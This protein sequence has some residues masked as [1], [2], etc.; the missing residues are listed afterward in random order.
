MPLIVTI[1]TSF[2]N[3][4]LGFVVYRK[5]PKSIT[6]I[7][8]AMITVIIACWTIANYFSLNSS[9][10]IQSLFW[11]QLVMFTTAPLGPVIYLF[12]NAYPF[13]EMKISKNK[14]IFITS[15][16][17]ILAVLSISPLT[18][19]RVSFANGVHPV[20]GP[21]VIMWGIVSL[22]FLILGIK[23]ILTKYR[24]SKGLVKLQL[25][26][27]ILGVILSFTLQFITNFLFVVILNYSNFVIFGP[28]FSLIMIGF[29]TY[30]IIRHRFL[31]IRLLVARTV[32]YTLL[33]AI[34]SIFYTAGFFIIISF[35]TNN[36]TKQELWISTVLTLVVAFSF[37]S[38]R[39]LLEK[40]TDKIFYKDHYDPQVLLEILGRIMASYISLSELISNLLEQLL[41]GIKVSQGALLLLKNNHVSWVKTLGYKLVPEFDEK[42]INQLTN[43]INENTSVNKK[44]IILFED[45]EEGMI[46]DIFRKNNFNLILPLTTKQ[47]GLGLLILGEKSS[48]DLYSYEDLQVLEILGP[49]MAVAIQNSLS[50]EEIRQFS[51]VL[52]EEV[53]Q[54]TSKL[55]NANEKLKE[56]DQ[57]KDE[58][59]SIASHE[60]RTPMTAVK[61]YLWMALYKSTKPFD[62]KTSE[63]LDIALKSTD[64]LINLVQDLLTISRIEGNR[65]VF[66]LET[67][68]ISLLAK[69]AYKELRIKA[70]EN[71]QQLSFIPAKEQLL[72]TLDKTRIMETIEN[73]LGN[74]LKFTP[75]KG[76]INFSVSKVDNMAEVRIQDT[77]PGISKEEQELLFQKFSRLENRPTSNAPGTGLGL[78]I[79]KQ[80]VSL[81]HGKIWVESKEGKGSTFIFSLPITKGN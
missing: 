70:D 12:L 3:L 61:S 46:K 54:A 28:S 32:A 78:Y 60:L 33:V 72:V 73:L 9:T 57:L 16:T 58:F 53:K 37:Q 30:A 55:Q 62:P 48:G 17:A 2:L 50:Y 41:T 44:E 75:A 5:N 6:N 4:L 24:Q 11:V 76:K 13:T 35:F 80:I 21:G 77:G 43:F 79:A 25:Q 71:H 63:Y 52:Q 66:N 47:E 36:V 14:A 39:H 18:F 81:H 31:D 40:Y 49:Q 65:L 27:L 38:L 74:A 68:D 67:L 22:V 8:L 59:V 19:S 20:P 26:Y 45:L 1:V 56:L 10:P 64:R 34:I 7:F 15:V 51:T 69:Q 23:A 42:E 29:I